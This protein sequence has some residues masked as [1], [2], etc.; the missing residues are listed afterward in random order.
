MADPTMDPER[1]AACLTKAGIPVPPG[2]LLY[3]TVQMQYQNWFVRTSKGWLWWS[4]KE[5]K[6]SVY[7]PL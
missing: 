1:I 2:E 6:P 7:G 3:C 4:G 5:W